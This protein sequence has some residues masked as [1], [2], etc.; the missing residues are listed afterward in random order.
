MCICRSEPGYQFDKE[1]LV[2]YN[3]MSFGGPP[4]TTDTVEQ[5]NELLSNYQKESEMGKLLIIY[6]F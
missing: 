5:A 3:H 1:L 2:E 4:I 6:C